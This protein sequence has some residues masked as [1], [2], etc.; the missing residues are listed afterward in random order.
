MD[1]DLLKVA[2]IAGAS[3]A[4]AFKEKNP[5]AT[6]QEILKHVA[7]RTTEILEKIEN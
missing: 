3:K 7:S 6:E 1:D 4:I 2:I 5:S